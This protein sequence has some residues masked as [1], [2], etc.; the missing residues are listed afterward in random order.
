MHRLRVISSL[1]VVTALATACAT[2]TS[3]DPYIY[4]SGDDYVQ[5]DPIEAGAP[6]NS[7]PLTI[8]P[9]QLREL[10]APLKVSHADTMGKAP[11]FNN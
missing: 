6:P 10:L 1:I 4:R 3:D 11:V 7:H 8:S 2:Q 5:V 9:S